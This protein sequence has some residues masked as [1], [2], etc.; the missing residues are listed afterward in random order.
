MSA[1]PLRMRRWRRT[2][3]EKLVEVGVFAFDERLELLDGLLVVREPQGSRHAAALGLAHDALRRAFGR[4]HWVRVQSPVALDET[5]EPEPDLSV[6]RGN[7]RRYR[8]AH[9]SAPLLVLEIA[10]TSLAIDRHRKGSLYAR[11]GIADYW[12]LNLLDGVL[13]I[14]RQPVRAA[15]ARYGWKYRTVRL[16]KRG[17]VITPLAAPSARI[18][19]ADLLP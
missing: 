4:N 12:I 11:R 5:S 3:Y 7:P 9:P 1:P 18:R 8:E 16:L 15:G 6:V 10:D 14:H 13:E 19:V 17:A 2:E